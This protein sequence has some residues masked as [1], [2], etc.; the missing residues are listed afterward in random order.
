LSTKL[1]KK[2]IDL[3]QWISQA[4]AA[5]LRGVTRQAIAKLVKKGKLRI[6]EIGGYSLV[7]RQEILEF[8]DGPAGRPRTKHGESTTNQANDK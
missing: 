6:L 1:I 5:R 2:S 7:N 8:K 3:S 4:E